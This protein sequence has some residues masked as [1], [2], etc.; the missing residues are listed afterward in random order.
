RAGGDVAGFAREHATVAARVL[1]PEE[2]AVLG[3]SVARLARERPDG[4]ASAVA[5]QAARLALHTGRAGCDEWADAV[6]AQLAAREIELEDAID[7]LHTACFLA[8]GASAAPCA[9]AA[10]VL[11]A[12]GRAPVALAVLCAGLGAGDPAWRAAQIAALAEPWAAGK[13]DLPLDAGRAA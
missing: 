10:R 9:Q 13:L 5:A 3:A 4:W 6:V 11:L 2:T 12:A 7:M 1:G 8:E